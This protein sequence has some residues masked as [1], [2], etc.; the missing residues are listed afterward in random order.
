MAKDFNKEAFAEDV[1]AGMTTREL[2]KKYNISD[3]RAKKQMERCNEEANGE[4]TEADAPAEDAEEM[5]NL[6]LTLPA[7]GVFAFLRGIPPNEI[8]EAIEQQPAQTAANL[9]ATI[10]QNRFDKELQP[11]TRATPQLVIAQGD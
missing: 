7:S 3:Y 5:F 11:R 10:M 8:L 9:L 1:I 6:E 4:A 2:A